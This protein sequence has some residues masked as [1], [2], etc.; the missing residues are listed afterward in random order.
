MSAASF[1][2]N[3]CYNINTVQIPGHS[4]CNAIFIHDTFIHLHAGALSHPPDP[5][6]WSLTSHTWESVHW[7][8]TFGYGVSATSR[9]LLNLSQWQAIPLDEFTGQQ[10]IKCFPCS[11]LK[12][13]KNLKSFLILHIKVFSKTK[14]GRSKVSA[15]AAKIPTFLQPK[16]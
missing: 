4:P 11:H 12:A 15:H 9:H 2:L 16:W 6:T 10:V 3:S 5:V 7:S 13:S 14:C 1:W 8:V